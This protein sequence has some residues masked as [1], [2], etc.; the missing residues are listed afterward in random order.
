MRAYYVVDGNIPPTSEWNILPHVPFSQ[1]HIPILP[2]IKS[3]VRIRDK[4]FTVTDIICTTA[5]D[6]NDYEWLVVLK[7]LN[8]LEVK[9][10]GGDIPVDIWDVVEGAIM[11]SAGMSPL[12]ASDIIRALINEGVKFSR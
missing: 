10:P 2:Q 8:A 11:R 9:I 1:C 6:V 7:P 3:T 12:Q 4:H 5:N